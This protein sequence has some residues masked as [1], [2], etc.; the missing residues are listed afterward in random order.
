MNANAK[1]DWG[2]KRSPTAL[3][4]SNACESAAALC[5]PAQSKTGARARGVEVILANHRCG[6]SKPALNRSDPASA[7]DEV[8]CNKWELFALLAF[9]AVSFLGMFFCGYVIVAKC[10]GTWPF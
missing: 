2:G 6:Y 3:E 9:V 1:Y 8:Q 10:R 7:V 5:L 4:H